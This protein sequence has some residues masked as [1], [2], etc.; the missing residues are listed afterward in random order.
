MHTLNS[1][2]ESNLTDGQTDSWFPIAVIGIGCRFP[3]GIEDPQAY[4]DFLIDKKCGITEVPPDRWSLDAHFDSDPDTYGKARSKWG[5]FLQRD[6]FGFDPAFF[7][8]SPREAM[9]M[10]PQQ[11]LLLQVAYEAVQHG[12]TTIDALQ[13]VRTGVFVGISTSDFGYS[14]RSR[15][16][17]GGILAGTGSALSISANRISHRFDFSG[18]SLAIDTACS[19]ALVAVDQAIRHLRMEMCDVALAGGVNCILDPGTFVAFSSA[20]MLSPTGAIYTFDERADGFVRSEGCGLILLKPLRQAIHDGD[21][22]CAVI[23]SSAVNQ[24]GRT[25]TLTAPS[26]SAQTS[27]LEHLVTKGSINPEDV[28]YV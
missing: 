21:R 16:N 20:N 13:R 2:L 6:V 11:R 18:P 28:A 26:E 19:S 15:S 7:D 23:R 27:M 17:S 8:I 25:A 10:D 1:A 22:I 4:W 14:Q 3:G 12:A 9:L 24:D 5:G